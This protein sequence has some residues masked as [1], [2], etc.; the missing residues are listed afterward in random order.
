MTIGSMINDQFSMIKG[1]VG[2][3]NLYLVICNLY[4]VTSDF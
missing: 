2:P 1:K 4:L 3:Y